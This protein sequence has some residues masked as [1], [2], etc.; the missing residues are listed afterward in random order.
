MKKFKIDITKTQEIEISENC[1]ISAVYIGKGENKSESKI[2]II[3]RKPDIKS[4]INIKA[5]LFDKAKFDF[6]GI[7]RIEKSAI[8]TDTYLKIDCLLLS[9]G[10]MARAIP[11]LEIKESAVKAGHGATIGYIDK[12]MMYYLQ[13][14]GLSDKEAESLIVEAFIKS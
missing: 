2:V 5:V 1:E 13:S 14:K 9:E 12:E 4:R 10:A 7:L 3:H 8:N 6:E 11:S